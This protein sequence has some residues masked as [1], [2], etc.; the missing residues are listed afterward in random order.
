NVEI[1]YLCDGVAKEF[2]FPYEYYD[3]SHVVGFVIGADGITTKITTNFTFNEVSKKFI[4]PVEGTALTSGNK[5]KLRRVTELSQ[6]LDLPNEYP[7]GNIELAQD[8][9]TMIM[10]ELN[11]VGVTSIP[12]VE[13]SLIDKLNTVI[14]NTNTV[15][16]YEAYALQHRNDAET[17]KNNASSSASNALTSANNA[18]TSETN[19]KL[20][21]NNAKTSE[22]NSK[23]SENNAKTSETNAKTSETN[24]KTSE[25]NSKTSETNSKLSETNSKLSETNAKTS[26]TNSKLSENNAKTSKDNAKTSETNSKLSEN[27]AKTSETNSKLSETNSK[28]SE[29][30][31]KTSETNSK[32]SENNAKTSET[33]AKLSETQAKIYAEQANGG[34]N[35]RKNSRAYATD[36]AVYSLSLPTWARLDCIRGGTTANTEPTWGTV[37]AGQVFTDGTVQWRIADVKSSGDSVGSIKAWLVKNIPAGWLDISTGAIVSRGTYPELWAWVQANA[38][39]IS[40]ADWQTQA[41]AQS[42]VG[43]FST[44][45]GSTT[46]RLPKIVDYVRGGILA[47]VGTWQGDAIRN[48]TGNLKYALLDAAQASG[49]FAINSIVAGVGA[50]SGSTNKRS[51]TLDISTQV[52]TADENRPK[53]I[54]MIYCIK[55][56]GTPVN[57]GLIDITQLANEVAGKQ[58]TI[59]Y[60]HIRDEK[61]SGT[62]GGTFTSGAWRTRDL[63][64]I[65]KDDTGQVVL[66]NNQF[67]LPAGKYEITAIVPAC[68]VGG[69]RARLQNI[70]DGATVIYSTPEDA[71]T[72]V[73]Y[74]NW[75]NITAVFTIATPKAFEI[76]HYTNLGFATT[77][78]GITTLTL[79]SVNEIYTQVLIRKVG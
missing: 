19:S 6:T 55:A 21:E 32:L 2:P 52:P 54:K 69:N 26:E 51:A 46:F 44:G 43:A 58:T 25:T 74:N 72:N 29:T 14:I 64:T 60:I 7:F 38:P 49:A 5:I 75:A 47:D 15:K 59:K 31:A 61:P 4:Y 9:L 79:A 71:N 22:T 45:D 70:T 36:D 78:F 28:L 67:T 20:S 66:L 33:N 10:Q 39:I 62:A 11:Y 50:G 16:E 73:I 17:F 56:F 24:S 12:E 23:L 65:V 68:R 40:E 30:N 1:T 42:S 41:N 35:T 27:N 18:K 63:N 8:K 13:Q 34:F 76:Q 3:K 57:Q 77:G 48:I 53:T 37:T